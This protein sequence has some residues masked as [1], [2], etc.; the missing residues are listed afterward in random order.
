MK[1]QRELSKKLSEVAGFP[2]PKLKLR[3]YLTPPNIAAA[4]LWTAYMNNDVK[5]KTV[6]DLGCGTGILSIG[7]SLLKAKEVTGFDIDE[8]ALSVAEKNA[9]RI[10]LNNCIFKISD[11][12]DVTGSC[13][14][15]VMNPPFMVRGGVND[16]FFLDKAFE[17]ASNVYSIHNLETHEF[18]NN[19]AKAKGY[20]PVIIDNFK[21]PL[22]YSYA[23]HEKQLVR[24]RVGLWMF[25]K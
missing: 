6:Y 15:V 19:Y 11:V 17:V 18:I 21:F 25:K 8:G 1:S 9:K 3:Q 2:M 7:A 16:K 13:D 12:R 5:G 24:F 20:K 10:G 22:K 23:F 4:L 14:T